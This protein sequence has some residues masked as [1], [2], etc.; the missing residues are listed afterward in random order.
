MISRTIG[1]AVEPPVPVWFSRATA[2]AIWASAAGANA[3]NHVVLR[4][5]TPVYAVPVFPATST[6]EI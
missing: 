5:A 6:P 4:P 3:T 2:T 1:A